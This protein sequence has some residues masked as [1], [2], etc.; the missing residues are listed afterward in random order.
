MDTELLH[1][2]SQATVHIKNR[3]SPICGQR[4]LGNWSDL[5][6]PR[7]LQMLIVPRNAE[8][9]RFGLPEGFAPVDHRFQTNMDV[10]QANLTFPTQTHIITTETSKY[11]GRRTFPITVTRSL[12]EN[13]AKRSSYP[14]KPLS[15]LAPCTG[16]VVS[17]IHSER[18][19]NVVTG[20]VFC[21][22][23]S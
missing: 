6:Q 21:L 11:R 15:A 19:K 2:G 5:P 13:P 20:D 16:H 23:F 14:G 10:I 4:R 12:G 7:M 8:K 1:P 9:L 22:V 3:R 17:G 18:D